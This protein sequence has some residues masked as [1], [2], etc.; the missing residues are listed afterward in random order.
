[1]H[2]FFVPAHSGEHDD[3]LLCGQDAKHAVKVLRL[4]EGD[5]FIAVDPGREQYV[6]RIVEAGVREVRAVIEG[7][8][9]IRTEPPV[10]V[11]LYQALPKADKMDHVVSRSTELGVRAIVPV[12]TDRTVVRPEQDRLESRLR[13]WQKIAEQSAELAGRTS[14]PQIATPVPY[15]EALRNSA[16][17]ALR[18]MPW[19]EE[20]ARGIKSVLRGSSARSA[21]VLIGPEGGF[22]RREAD[23]AMGAGVLPVTLGPR[24]MR[25][26]NA[27]AVVLA[28]IMYE[29][30]DMC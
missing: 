7:V 20:R 4:R 12:L 14:C 18:I 28:M 19:E 15:A 29:L 25:T 10:D 6:A 23:E 13:R 26:E 21:F 3:V 16:A 5:R 2:R 27:G 22:T 9:D 1:M 11:W 24:M 30:G 8:V 17:H